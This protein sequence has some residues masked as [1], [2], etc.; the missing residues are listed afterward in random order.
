MK[1]C[2]ILEQTI[3]ALNDVMK[4]RE[5]E[6]IYKTKGMDVPSPASLVTE[7]QEHLKKAEAELYK[8]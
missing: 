8:Q 1:G 3:E 5:E 7:A 2:D 4:V 6:L